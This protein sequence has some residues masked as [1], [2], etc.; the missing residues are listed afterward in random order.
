MTGP[1][2]NPLAD[3]ADDAIC[4]AGA[5]TAVVQEVHLVAI[6]ALCDALDARISEVTAQ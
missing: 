5:D 2:P 4:V 1:A 3:L 6:H